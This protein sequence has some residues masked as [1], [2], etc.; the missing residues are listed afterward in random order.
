MKFLDYSVVFSFKESVVFLHL[1]IKLRRNYLGLLTSSLQYTNP[2]HFTWIH[3]IKVSAER[4]TDLP[5]NFLA[6]LRE[7]LMSFQNENRTQGNP[8][9]VSTFAVLV[10]CIQQETS[11]VFDDLN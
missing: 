8:E 11:V 7:I 5:A 9:L 3:G 6:R 2:V 1:H 4:F 10:M